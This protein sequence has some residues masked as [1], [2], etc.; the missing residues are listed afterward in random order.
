MLFLDSA[1]D[2]ECAHWVATALVRGVTTNSTLLMK[3][4]VK[5]ATAAADRILG[6]GAPEVHVQVMAEEPERAFE[7]A[8]ELAAFDPRIV[9]KIP[10]VTASGRLR[11]D[12]VGRCVETGIPVNV[13]ACTTLAQG[14]AALAVGPRYVSLLWCRTRDTGEDPRRVVTS[15]VSRRDRLGNGTR[16]LVGSVREPRD[17]TD[18]LEAGA[19]VVTVPPHVL[20]PW[21]SSDASLAMARQFRDDALGLEL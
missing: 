1:D 4:G 16:A 20:G 17:L 13:T 5:R 8:G 6:F 15:L 21:L 19:D 3:A 2:A 18:A 12:V 14:L 9:V 11:T 10:F 7:Q